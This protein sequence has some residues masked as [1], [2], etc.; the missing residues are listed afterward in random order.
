MVSQ[1]CLRHALGVGAEVAYSSTR[2]SK[3]DKL[4]PSSYKLVDFDP[5]AC[6]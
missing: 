3:R 4:S 6:K 5:D 2:R 1:V